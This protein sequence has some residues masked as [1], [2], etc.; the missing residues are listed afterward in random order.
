MAF[1]WG[2]RTLCGASATKYVAIGCNLLGASR[3][4][5]SSCGCYASQPSHKFKNWLFWDLLREQRVKEIYFTGMLTHG[6]S[7]FFIR[8]I[9]PDSRTV[10]SYHP[11]FI[12]QREEPDGGLKYVIVEVKADNQIE[13]AVVQAKKDF[14]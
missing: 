7:D 8:Y 6:Q 1:S 4:T 14:A 2:V 13:D 5:A 9:D 3:R 11:D 12:F 10:R